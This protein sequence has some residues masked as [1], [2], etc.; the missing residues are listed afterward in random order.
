MPVKKE[1]E[2]EGGKGHGSGCSPEGESVHGVLFLEAF[3][4][5]LQARILGEGRSQ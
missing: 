3:L 5:F 1:A 4:S 2:E